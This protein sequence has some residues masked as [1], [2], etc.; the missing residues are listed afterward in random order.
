MSRNDN[1]KMQKRKYRKIDQA[2]PEIANRIRE[3]SEQT[4]YPRYCII[5]L[6]VKG[7]LSTDLS[8]EHDKHMRDYILPV[9]LKNRIFLKATLSKIGGHDAQLKFVDSLREETPFHDYIRSRLLKLRQNGKNLRLEVVIADLRNGGPYIKLA[10]KVDDSKLK[11]MIKIIKNKIHLVE[12]RKKAKSGGH[13]KL[14]WLKKQLVII[15]ASTM[16]FG[17]D[18]DFEK[19]I[20][21][22]NTYNSRTIGA[23][24]DQLGIDHPFTV[25]EQK[26]VL[27]LAAR[28]VF[29]YLNENLPVNKIDTEYG[30]GTSARLH[31]YSNGRCAAQEEHK[32]TLSQIL[33]K[34]WWLKDSFE[35]HP[36]DLGISETIISTTDSIDPT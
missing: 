17:D 23:R 11:N 19:A 25:E 1:P 33:Y 6:M 13:K 36:V 24:L 31:A 35:D 30:A 5:D 3:F 27:K 16:N 34:L 9:L 21:T 10:K 8:S 14:K 7:T 15:D 28:N 32:A 20:S 29:Q 2:D 22:S 26:R 18:F 12:N 4:G